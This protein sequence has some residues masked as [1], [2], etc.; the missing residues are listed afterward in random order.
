MGGGNQPPRPA[1]GLCKYQIINCPGQ[2]LSKKS[3]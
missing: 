1:N 2:G 3:F